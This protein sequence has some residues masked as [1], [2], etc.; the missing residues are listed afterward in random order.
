MA[1][2]LIVVAATVAL[3]SGFGAEPVAAFSTGIVDHSGNPDELVGGGATC[4]SCHTPALDAPTLLIAGPTAIVGGETAD[5]TVTITGGPGTAGGLNVSVSDQAGTLIPDNVETRLSSDQITHTAAK[6]FVD[7]FAS[8]TFQWTAPVEAGDV[9]IYAAGL[10]S[11]GSG[12]TDGDGVANASL[13]VAVTAPPVLGDVNCSGEANIVDAL[14]IAQFEVGNR[15][16]GGVCPLTDPTSELVL[17]QA[18][19]NNDNNANIVDA[20]LIAQCDT[21]ITNVFCPPPDP[22]EE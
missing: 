13:Q 5:I 10:S 6:A 1:G 18:D 4:A 22:P 12:D 2:G 11:D 3:A 7:G 20:L 15:S 9:V 8:F 19:V 21:G 17:G 14:F 16:D